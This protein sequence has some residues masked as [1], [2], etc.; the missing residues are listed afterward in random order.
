M[1]YAAKIWRMLYIRHIMAIKVLKL[2]F[3]WHS[4]FKNGTILEGRMSHSTKK[5]FIK[6][7]DHYLESY[8]NIRP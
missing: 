1:Q 8:F 3:L 7:N 6:L 2:F 4:P 5:S